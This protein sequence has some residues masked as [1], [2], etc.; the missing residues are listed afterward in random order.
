MRVCELFCAADNFCRVFE[1]HW[2][3]HRLNDNAKKHHRP[4]KLVLRDIVTM[5][6]LFY[7]SRERTFNTFSTIHVPPSPQQVSPSGQL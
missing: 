4:R 1:P 7:R 3:H 2:P 5:L 6:I